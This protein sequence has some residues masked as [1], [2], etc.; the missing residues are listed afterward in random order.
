MSLGVLCGVGGD[1]PDRLRLSVGFVLGNDLLSWIIDLLTFVFES[2]LSSSPSPSPSLS[3]SVFGVSRVSADCKEDEEED[4]DVAGE[5]VRGYASSKPSLLPLRLRFL[6]VRGS[7]AK[8]DEEE[9]EEEEEE[10]EEEP[11][12]PP[13]P[14][15]LLLLLLLLSLRLRDR[16]VLEIVKGSMASASESSESVLLNFDRMLGLDVATSTGRPTEETT[17]WPDLEVTQMQALVAPA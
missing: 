12:P 6:P 2:F 13:P 4:D 8:R 9:E 16:L 5:S 17:K 7:C 14:L 3:P 1:E 10:S 11:P 15:L